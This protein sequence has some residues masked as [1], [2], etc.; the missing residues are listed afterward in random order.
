MLQLLTT[1]WVMPTPSLKDDSPQP[2]PLNWE[3]NPI[4]YGMEHPFGQ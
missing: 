1:H 2:Q 3:L 4:L